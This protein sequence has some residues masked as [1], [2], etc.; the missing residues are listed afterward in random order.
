MFTRFDV[1]R[2]ASI[3]CTIKTTSDQ[4]FFVPIRPGC[5]GKSSITS[6]STSKT[7]SQQIFW[8]NVDLNLIF[9]SWTVNAH[10]VGHG[11][12]C[13]KGQHEPQPPW[14]QIMEMDLQVGHFLRGSNSF[15]SSSIPTSLAFLG[16]KYFL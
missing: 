5:T 11:R 8:G 9:T 6:K 16:G 2:L 10:S 7:T 14:S 3:V 15:G 12:G 1:I 13:S 4:A